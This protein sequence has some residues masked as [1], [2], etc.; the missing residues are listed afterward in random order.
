MT[1]LSCGTWQIMIK[2][3][4]LIAFC[5]LA[6]GVEAAVGQENTTVLIYH[7]FGEEQSPTTNVSLANFARQMAWLRDNDYRVLPLAQLVRL[8]AD[9]AAVPDRAVV[10]TIDD[11]YKSVYT[12]AWPILRRYGYPF[13]VF[14]Y[15]KAV[16]KKYREFL[17]W[18]EIKEMRAAGV[19]FQGH[20][21]SHYH[22]GNRPAGLTDSGYA[23]WIRAD[24][25][26]GR[27]VLQRHLGRRPEFLALPYGEY[28]S[29]ITRQCREIGYKAIFSQ[30]PGSVSSDTGY[31]IPREP[32]LGYEWSTLA[33]FKAVLARTDLPISNIEP[34]T[35][36][37]TGQIKQFCATLLYPRRYDL[38]TLNIYVSELGWQRPDKING[39]RVCLTNNRD[40]KLRMN[41]VAISARDKLT[42]RQAVRFWLLMK[43]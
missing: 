17:S 37:F 24:L 18:K 29:I 32:I 1:A 14:L 15:A 21:Y 35:A 12:G 20:S 34:E 4:L 11:G 10:I 7:K 2:T 27:A 36:P 39:S 31:V 25:E 19:D 23:H 42:R 3:F 6:L 38:R 30:D 5:L 22:L 16:E 43:R 41:R 13:T 9:Q 8:L 28:N 26:K 33:H 40:L